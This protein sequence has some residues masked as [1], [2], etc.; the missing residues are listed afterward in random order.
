MRALRLLILVALASGPACN[1]SDGVSRSV[2]ARCDANDE[3]DS[4]CL[5]GASYPDGFCTLSC[6]DDGDCP[7][8]TRCVEVEGGVCLFPCIEAAACAFLGTGWDCTDVRPRPDDPQLE[9]AKI[10][11]AD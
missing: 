2:G 1:D 6:D 9:D 8:N 4:R 11:R 5:M 10:C 7:G 3:C